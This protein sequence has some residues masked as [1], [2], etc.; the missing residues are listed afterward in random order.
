MNYELNEITSKTS[1]WLTP[2]AKSFLEPVIKDYWVQEFYEDSDVFEHVT[3]VRMNHAGVPLGVVLQKQSNAFVSRVFAGNIRIHM[4]P[5]REGELDNRFTGIPCDV[6]TPVE[7]HF[8][9]PHDRGPL[10][11]HGCMLFARPP[12]LII[13]ENGER[14]DKWFWVPDA[15]NEL[16]Q[17]VI[18]DLSWRFNVERRDPEETQHIQPPVP[19]L[20]KFCIYTRP[21]K[22]LPIE[23]DLMVACQPDCISVCPS[24]QWCTPLAIIFDKKVAEHYMVTRLIM[25]DMTYF[26]FERPIHAT[27]FIAGQRTLP[28]IPFMLVPP[29]QTISLEGIKCHPYRKCPP[30]EARIAMAVGDR[31]IA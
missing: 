1:H 12:K 6:N 13:P 14:G 19:P 22:A 30:F 10:C 3:T 4:S 7:I 17:A 9:A 21:M 26:E 25:G 27:E 8:G 11:A 31:C 2:P 28:A 5:F 23:S 15:N 16:H 24:D 18:R 29:R 20:K